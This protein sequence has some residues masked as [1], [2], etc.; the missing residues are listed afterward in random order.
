MTTID[1]QGLLFA[2]DFNQPE[3]L[4]SFELAAELDS[5]ASMLAWGVQYAIGP[6]A[7]RH[8]PLETCM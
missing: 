2:W 3:A 8:C 5:E 7:N 6:G 4:K 1:L